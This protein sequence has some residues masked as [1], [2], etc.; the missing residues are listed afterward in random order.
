MPEDSPPSDEATKYSLIDLHVK[1]DMDPVTGKVEGAAF[2][3]MEQMPLCDRWRCDYNPARI[4]REILEPLRA[5]IERPPTPE[6]LQAIGNSVSK[7]LLPPPLLSA[8][9]G[10]LRQIPLK[11]ERRLRLRITTNDPILSDIP[12]EFCCASLTSAGSVGSA[13]YLSLEPALHIF[14]QSG[15]S[16]TPAS[17]SRPRLSELRVLV[18]WANPATPA[19]PML[20]SAR[21]EARSLIGVL[22][23]SPE[24]RRSVVREL[25]DA[26]LE[27]LAQ[28]VSD[29]RPNIVHFVGHGSSSGREPAIV[30][31]SATGHQRVGVSRVS[32][33]LNY[34][35][36][37]LLCLSACDTAPFA[38][39]ATASGKITAAVAMQLPW[40]DSIAAQ[41][42]RAFYSALTLSQSAEDA[43]WEGRQAI[44]GT[45][46]DWGNPV[47]YINAADS[48]IFDLSPAETPNNLP[49]RQA[50]EFVGREATLQDLDATLNQDPRA[51]VAIVGMPGM[52]KT[53]LAIEY[54]HRRKHLY[55][56]GVYWIRSRNLT[57]IRESLEEIAEYFGVPEGVS[58]RAK[59][60]IERINSSHARS[61]LIYDNMLETPPHEWLPDRH[62]FIATTTDADIVRSLCQL[63][64]LPDLEHDTAVD[65][66]VM[67]RKGCS[68]DERNAASAIVSRMGSLPLALALAANH[69]DRLGIGY[70]AYRELLEQDVVAT[71]TRARKQFM[72]HTGHTGSLFDTMAISF[73]RLDRNAKRLLQ[74]GTCLATRGIRR[75]ILLRAAGLADK[76]YEIAVSEAIADITTLSL[77]T[78][79]SDSRFAIHQLIREFVWFRMPSDRRRKCAIDAASALRTGLEIANR[80]SDWKEVRQDL[81]HVQA[82]EERCISE[83]QWESLYSLAI[84]AGICKREHSDADEAE[85]QFSMAIN[86]ANIAYGQDSLQSARAKLHYATIAAVELKQVDLAVTMCEDALSAAVKALP[87]KSD[88]LADYYNDAGFV[89]KHCKDPLRALELYDKSMKA[90]TDLSGATFASAVNNRGAAFEALDRYDDAIENYLHAMRLDSRLFGEQHNKVAIR[91]NN[92]GR[93]YCKNGRANQ[94][95]DMHKRAEKIYIETFGQYHPNV[96]AS[97]YYLGEAETSLG[98]YEAALDHYN[99]AI[100]IYLRF[101][102]ADSWR[103]VKVREAIEQAKTLSAAS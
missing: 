57:E 67:R 3:F 80:T 84:E 33:M 37:R 40:R 95:L 43:L 56:G 81:H 96:A 42:A 75:D 97:C 32:E 4:E 76:R 17:A 41:F 7:M 25:P 35:E 20:A 9:D 92:A 44:R 8:I 85:R 22:Q 5:H 99:E 15:D 86:A 54:G 24:C 58:E 12:W 36:F 98:R 26:T 11:H 53:L 6:N 91:L 65:F 39:Q 59:R 69:A 19:F 63:I 31:K 62:H 100:E 102:D 71:L 89:I 79:E 48:E 46:A 2:S 101:Y 64:Q 13:N 68:P 83:T 70:G 16:V 94:A 77:G 93:L 103:V 28:A 49:F 21:A 72:N 29:L 90:A 55:P 38:Q 23:D 27:S 50:H 60:V 14:R 74:T 82:I 66:L 73:A 61:L 18:V 88:E 1:I 52:G 30:L 34:P 45:G 47:L 10:K 78:R 87:A 51:A